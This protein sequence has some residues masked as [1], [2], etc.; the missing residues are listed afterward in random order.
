MQDKDDIIFS[1]EGES[2]G[3]QTTYP[4]SEVGKAMD[5]WVKQQA[6]EFAKWICSHKLDFQTA[7]D[8]KW[9]G[10][11]LETYTNEELYELFLNKDNPNDIPSTVG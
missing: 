1:L 10:L 9:I 7:S 2:D 11:N 8:N 4:H 3:W 5:I 6:I